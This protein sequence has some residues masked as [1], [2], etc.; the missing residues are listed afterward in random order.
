MHK[1][2][3]DKITEILE[4]CPYK[5]NFQVYSSKHK[6]GI[7][8]EMIIFTKGMNHYINNLAQ[9]IGS[10]YGEHLFIDCVEGTNIKEPE[11]EFKDY[12]RLG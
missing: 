2:I 12:V 1:K 3:V 8:W 4:D 7:G 9:S 10:I 11:E 5:N 6:S